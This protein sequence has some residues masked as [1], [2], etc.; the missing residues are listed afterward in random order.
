MPKAELAKRYIEQRSALP[1][2][3]RLEPFRTIS[4]LE[5]RRL[6]DEGLPPRLHAEMLAESGLE[7]EAR[8]PQSQ[9]PGDISPPAGSEETRPR[10]QRPVNAGGVTD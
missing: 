4:H 5:V 1:P 6:V 10:R 8:E 9:R 3:K 7:L 2:R